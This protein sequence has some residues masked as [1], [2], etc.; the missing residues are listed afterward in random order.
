MKYLCKTGKRRCYVCKKIKKLNSDNFY[1]DTHHS[2]GFCYICKECEKIRGKKRVHKYKY[3]PRNN[4]RRIKL[5]FNVLNRDNF[6][7]QYCGRKAPEVSLEI[8]HITPKSKGGI[9]EL[10]NYNTSCRE[11]NRGKGDALLK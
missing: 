9:N 11:C 4:K 8:D 10:K 1:K 5:R 6:T 3:R 7:C 2:T